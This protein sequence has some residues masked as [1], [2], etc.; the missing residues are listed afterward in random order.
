VSRA[1]SEG[2][3]WHEGQAWIGAL[4]RPAQPD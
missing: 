1:W 2:L 3:G 4:D